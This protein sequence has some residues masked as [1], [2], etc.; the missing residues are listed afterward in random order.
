MA[1]AVNF[2]EE[3]SEPSNFCETKSQIET[4]V[5]RHNETDTRVVLVT[6]NHPMSVKVLPLYTVFTAPRHLS[7]TSSTST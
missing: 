5:A 7:L 3:T 6:V 4:F 2:F 1:E